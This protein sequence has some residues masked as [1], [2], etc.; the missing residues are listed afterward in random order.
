MRELREGELLG[1]H[2]REAA[3]S[4]ILESHREHKQSDVS[5]GRES[6]AQQGGMENLCQKRRCRC[7]VHRD[8][9]SALDLMEGSIGKIERSLA[10]GFESNGL[11]DIVQTT[12]VES[13]VVRVLTYVISTLRLIA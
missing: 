10:K 5:N 3:Q 1:R 7:F 8:G 11:S 6:K 13:G 2:R 9:N 12:E 4:E